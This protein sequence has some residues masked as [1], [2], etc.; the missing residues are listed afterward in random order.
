MAFEVSRRQQPTTGGLNGTIFTLKNTDKG[1]QIEVWPALGF[2]CIQWLASVL[3]EGKLV[4]VL[5]ADPELFDN[6]RPTRS[7]IP[8]LFPFPNRIKEG[9]FTWQGNQ[10]QLPLTD[11]AKKNAAHGFVCRRPWRVIDEGTDESSAWLTGEFELAREDPESREHWPANFVLRVTYRLSTRRLRIEAEVG[12][13]DQKA[14]PFGLGYHP[15]FRIPLLP[16]GSAGTCQVEVPATHY[17]VLDESIPTGEMRP[18]DEKRDLVNPRPYSEVEV[19]DVL[20]LLPPD[21][22]TTP[23]GF[24]LNGTIHDGNVRLQLFSSPCFREIVVFTPPHREAFCIEPYT[25]PTNAVNLASDED[26]VGWTSIESGQTWKSVVTMT[27]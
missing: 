6:G 24:H 11:S 13:P 17:W 15:Y 9:R 1:D 3:P 2:N 22:T 18:V 8:I 27:I 23:E 12:N 10:Y 25:C 21:A 26:D 7:G 5:Y 4:D 19:D 20:T 14:L 16:T